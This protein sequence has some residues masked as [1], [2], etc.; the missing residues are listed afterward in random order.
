MLQNQT[1]NYRR[2][3]SKLIF[4]WI[5]LLLVNKK[6]KIEVRTITVIIFF[7]N[8]Q[9]VLW[10][11]SPLVAQFATYEEE[12]FRCANKKEK[13]HDSTKFAN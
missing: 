1:I 6:L 11:T 13:N 5:T 7:L 10:L 4:I 2:Y 12:C 8:D 9:V 3:L